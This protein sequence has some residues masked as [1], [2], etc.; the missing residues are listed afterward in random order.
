MKNSKNSWKNSNQE[1]R[2][3]YEKIINKLTEAGYK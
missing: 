1:T 2:V 3:I